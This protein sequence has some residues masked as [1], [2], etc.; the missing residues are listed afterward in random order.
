MWSV[1]NNSEV[2][3]NTIFWVFL[4]LCLSGNPLICVNEHIREIYAVSAISL[5]LFRVLF[6]KLDVTS[7]IK[8]CW[9]FFLIS[10]CQIIIINASLSSTIFMLLKLYV[11]FAIIRIL[12][13][14]FVKG[15]I[16]VMFMLALIS[17]PFFI[18]NMY[19]GYIPGIPF[20]E[21]G[22]SLGLYTEIFG[23]GLIL[24]KRNS[25]MF[26]E[27]GAFQGYLNIA[28]YFALL[29]PNLKRKF[30]KVVVLIIAVLTTKSTTGYFV[31]FL[32]LLYY[33]LFLRKSSIIS[34]TIFLILLIS[35]FIYAYYGLN[36]LQD[37]IVEESTK[38]INQGGRINDYIKYGSLILSN[39]FLGVSASV[40]EIA[41]SGNGFVS[42]LLYYGIF[43]VGY[44]F[45]ILYKNIR[46]QI[47]YK[48]TVLFVLLVLIT[49]QGEG[50]IYYPLYLVL[51]LITFDT[52]IRTQGAIAY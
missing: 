44:Y 11:G 5:L 49:L 38:D 18:Y 29:Q 51:P 26:W 3:I 7:F 32:I 35:S 17:L 34:K 24:I 52:D 2:S 50:F 25:G 37:K 6:N 23:D 12:G 42:F 41:P 16:E 15:Y 47:N 33:I 19:R 30:L 48:Y 8:Y 22:V 45:F 28:I 46:R 1:K 43:G 20:S 10:F 40:A 13:R 27:P 39:F 9:P 31:V 14:K 36:F 4:L 21:I